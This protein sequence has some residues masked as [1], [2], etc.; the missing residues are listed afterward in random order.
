MSYSPV[1]IQNDPPLF[2]SYEQTGQSP[3]FAPT[4]GYGF[5][6][7]PS[8]TNSVSPEDRLDDDFSQQ[9]QSQRLDPILLLQLDEWEEGGGIR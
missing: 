7:T 5:C 1:D 9:H 2:D 3:L 4:P 8:V 6:Q